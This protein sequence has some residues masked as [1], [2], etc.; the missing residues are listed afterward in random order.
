MIKT[1][2]ATEAVVSECRLMVEASGGKETEEVKA[3]IDSKPAGHV[4]MY[5][6]IFV[7]LAYGGSE[8][9]FI[10][11]TWPRKRE[12]KPVAD[13]ARKPQGHEKYLMEVDEQW[14]KD[15]RVK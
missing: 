8:Q 1:V 10:G 4:D 3:W 6:E 13:Q 12:W 7:G 9:E 5:L 11:A 15:R 2:T 14:R